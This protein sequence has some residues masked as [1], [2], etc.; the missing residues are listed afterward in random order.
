MCDIRTFLNRAKKGSSRFRKILCREN[1]DYSP[2]NIIKFSSNTETIIGMELSK[3]V[4]VV[5]KNSFFNNSTRTFLFKLHNNT[6]GYNSAVSHFVRNHS[7][8]CT[9]CDIGG[10]PEIVPETPLHLFFM[11]DIIED[12]LD[13]FYCWLSGDPD[14]T[15]TR[16]EFFT[17][18]NRDNFCPAKN[19][20]LTITGKLALRF[21]WDCKQRFCLPDLTHL[22][23]SVKLELESVSSINKCLKHKIR[24]C[25]LL[26]ITNI[27]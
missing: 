27:F 18:F 7:S 12:I 4:N 8:N 16:Q 15:F 1:L 2:H 26:G 14:F 24:D 5:W 25:G 19:E 6:L 20:V 10:N 22:K 11:C 21:I 9:F 23:T 17:E 13:D 3:R